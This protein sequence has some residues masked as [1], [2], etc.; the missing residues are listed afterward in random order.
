MN[1]L[2]LVIEVA[3]D[4]SGAL[5]LS[6][7]AMPLPAAGEVRIQVHAAGVNRGDIKQRHGDYPKLPEGA[8]NVLGL[9]VAGVV[10]A[11]GD[12]VTRWRPGDRV[13]AL[14]MGGGYAEYCTAPAEQC[15]PVPAGLDMVQAAALPET[16]ATVWQTLFMQAGLQPGE[17][18]L[19][20]GG[21]SGI[22][23]AAVQLARALGSRV[24][25]TAGSAE[26]CRLCEHLGADLAINYRTQD[27]AERALAFT[28]DQGVDVILDMVGGPYAASNLRILAP[29]G[30]LA[31][32]AGDAGGEASF[33]IRDIMMRRLTVTGATL[34]H[35]S[36]GE[37]G[38]ILAAL[39]RVAWPLLESGAIAPVV[40]RV[41]PLREAAAAHAWLEA[42]TAVGKTLLRVR[43]APSSSLSTGPAQETP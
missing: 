18:V 43:A 15:L 21:S 1:G 17:T 38:Q 25:V 11:C 33:N 14:L 9:E 3:P 2:N 41:F 39:Q 20:H 8:S 28:G 32:V 4:G 7:R 31:Y 19:V 5:V 6:H 30:R 12:G 22:G 26:K 34:R 40:D 35:R 37:K 42:G 29:R 10:D 23:V 13:C 16:F 24:L 27:F 36:V